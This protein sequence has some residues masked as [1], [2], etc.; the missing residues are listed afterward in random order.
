[1]VVMGKTTK[2]EK[3]Y[4]SLQQ[5]QFSTRIPDDLA[6]AIDAYCEEFGVN[7][8]DFAIAAFNMLLNSCQRIGNDNVSRAEFD[9]LIQT[10]QELAKKLA[11]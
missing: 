11:A 5:P 10:V 8:R 6:V 2:T 1:M 9:Q 4:P 3:S 7:K